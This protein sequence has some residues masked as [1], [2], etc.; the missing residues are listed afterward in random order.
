M[1]IPAGLAAF[2]VLSCRGKL[3]VQVN[4]ENISPGDLEKKKKSIDWWRQLY[5]DHIFDENGFY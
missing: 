5:L 4:Y 2:T 3:Q 1:K